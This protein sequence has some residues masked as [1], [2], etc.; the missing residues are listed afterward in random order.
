MASKFGTVVKKLSNKRKA[1]LF[2]IIGFFVIIL[3]S[4]IKAAYA[5]YHDSLT[6]GILANKV[7][8]FDG[9]DGDV[10][11]MV[12]KIENGK[13]IRIYAVP[14]AYYT[15]ND[16]LTSC[17]DK[18]NKTIACN[19]G[20]GNCNYSYDDVNR[21]F[22][23]TSNQKISCKFYFEKVSDSD[24]NLYVYV[25]DENGSE[26]YTYSTVD[27]EGNTV[28]VTK[29]YALKDNIPAY[30]YEYSNSYQCDSNAELTYDSE[31]RKFTVSTSTKN[32]CSVY[33]NSVGSSDITSNVYVQS[34]YGSDVYNSVSSI[35]S[36]RLYALNTS[37]SYC[38][39]ANGNNTGATIT[40]MNG[41]IDISANIQQTCDIYLDLQSE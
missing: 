20:T 31:T 13:P 33:F 9:G 4:G 16:S 8:D 10:N 11:L 17:V 22:T 36:N 15:F 34:T 32:N 25:E 41:Y 19:D 26:N 14:E 5:Y 29:T 37:K 21:N 2:M 24:I 27:T 30:G 1:C 28:S 39:D 40:Y 6:S 35:P 7:G 12:Y 23:V 3:S 18:N 38:Y